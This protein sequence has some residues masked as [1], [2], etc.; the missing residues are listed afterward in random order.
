MTYISDS[1]ENFASSRKLDNSFSSQGKKSMKSFETHWRPAKSVW[2]NRKRYR[3]NHFGSSTADTDIQTH[4]ANDVE[5][6]RK[7]VLDLSHEL[8][9]NLR[10]N[11]N[12]C[13]RKELPLELKAAELTSW[14][15]HEYHTKLIKTSLSQRRDW[16]A[17]SKLEPLSYQPRANFDDRFLNNKL[18]VLGRKQNLAERHGDRFKEHGRDVVETSH[19]CST[20]NHV[21]EW[22]EAFTKA[23]VK[24][25]NEVFLTL[26]ETKN[27]KFRARRLKCSCLFHQ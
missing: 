27:V 2:K 22:G 26:S 5:P 7:R 13:K 8:N 9:K 15:N 23:R 20:S 18:S 17:S 19:S 12:V 10:Q 3:L 14:T 24:K 11:D 1:C 21:R 6:L 4:H 25:L 16:T